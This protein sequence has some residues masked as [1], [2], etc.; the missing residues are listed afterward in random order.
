ML[1]KND[2]STHTHTY[3]HINMQIQV[4]CVCTCV[5]AREK[6]AHTK[7]IFTVVISVC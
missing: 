7:I 6:T 4:V 2:Y 3:I 5:L 1:V